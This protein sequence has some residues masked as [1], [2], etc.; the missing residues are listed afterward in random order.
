MK[1]ILFVNACL[2]GKEKSRTWLL[3]QAFLEA[4][5]KRWPQV[6]IKERDL[7]AC[8]L[9]ILTGPLTEERDRL[10]VEAPEDPMFAPAR[11]MAQA[12]L[13][14]IAAPYWDLTFPA[15]LKVYLEW[16]STLGITFH[17][18][19]HGQEGLCRAEHVVYITTAGGPIGEQNFGFDYVG[20][21]G[22]MLG[23]PQAHCLSAEGLDVWGNDPQA[24]LEEAK[25]QAQKLAAAL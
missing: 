3:S 4:C 13:V 8:D 11:E 25:V 17:Y 21:L 18:T 20:G 9:P 23:I 24:I 16:A 12:D 14:V 6:E 10:V 22:R 15:A 1:E 5:R 7:T 2:R 19:E